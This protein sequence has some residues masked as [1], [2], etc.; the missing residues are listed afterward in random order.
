MG[1]VT[2]ALLAIPLFAVAAGE[3]AQQ[4]RLAESNV[5]ES[6][7]LIQPIN[8]G[9]NNRHAVPKQMKERAG[10]LCPSGYAL[11]KAETW[12]LSAHNTQDTELLWHIK[13]NAE[14]T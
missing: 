6:H 1:T 14:Q 9:K 3:G 8:S 12:S 13:C 10:T 7:V 2:I 11:L 4:I 5:G